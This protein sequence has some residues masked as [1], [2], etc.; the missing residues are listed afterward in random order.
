MITIGKRFEFAAAHRLGRHEGKCKNPHGHNYVLEIDLT[1]PN[2]LHGSGQHMI[3]DYYIVKQIIEHE[4]MQRFDHKDLNVEVL[5]YWPDAAPEV[6]N[7]TTAENL[8]TLFAQILGP[9]FYAVAPNVL[10]SRLR[11]C[12]TSSSWAEWRP[13]TE[14]PLSYIAGISCGQGSD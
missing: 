10:I 7:I 11:L 5:K 4:I 2:E 12:E 8:V 9:A 1:G 3:L 13:E 6:D 14:M